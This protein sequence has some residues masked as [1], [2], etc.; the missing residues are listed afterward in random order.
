VEFNKY[1]KKIIQKIKKQKKINAKSITLSAGS[2]LVS[3]LHSGL[4]LFFASETRGFDFG[5]KWQ[6]FWKR[7]VS[8]RSFQ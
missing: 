3:A 6:E 2:H 7:D 5:W 4:S 8:S 1:P